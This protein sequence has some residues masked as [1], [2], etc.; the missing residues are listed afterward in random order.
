MVSRIREVAAT[1]DRYQNRE[2]YDRGSVGATPQLNAD[3]VRPTGLG[4]LITGLDKFLDG[5]KE[6]VSKDTL[7][8]AQK[9]GATAGLEPDFKEREDNTLAA[10]AYNRAGV[11]IFLNKTSTDIS[12][13]VNKI[14]MDPKYRNDP[15]GL[16]QALEEVNGAMSQHIPASMYPQFQVAFGARAQHAITQAQSRAYE[17]QLSSNLATFMENE[18]VLV[19]EATQA[20]RSGDPIVMAQAQ[21]E[22]LASV[23]RQIG[24]GLTPAEAM[25]RTL[26]FEKTLRG[27][28][29]IGEFLRQKPEDRL[30]YAKAFIENNPMADL[31]TPQEADDIKQKMW[32]AWDVDETLKEKSEVE[33]SKAQK[34]INDNALGELYLNPTPETYKNFVTMPGVTADQKRAAK[35]YMTENRNA[36][37]PVAVSY[38]ED[39]IYSGNHEEAR[40]ALLD[41]DQSRSIS[42]REI[43]RLMGMI[44]TEESGAGFEQ[45]EPYKEVL[46]RIK[47]DYTQATAFGTGLSPEGMSLR[48]QVYDKLRTDYPKYLRGE[49]SYEEVDPLRIYQLKRTNVKKATS[50]VGTGRE[51]TTQNGVVVVPQKYIDAPET[52]QQD[53]RGTGIPPH[54]RSVEVQK[55]MAD[56]MI[57]KLKQTKATTDGQ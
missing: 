7:R 19:A 2:N 37:D 14:A 5:A 54:L 12:T 56:T 23:Q 41:E 20:A 17:Q 22:Y 55:F 18:A 53:L 24:L 34:R 46:R 30:A 3:V 42:Q 45:T 4:E 8:A 11:E 13:R 57:D 35:S 29:A 40:Q 1:A 51:I 49:V 16:Q 28:A 25:K 43:R 21:Q 48:Q 32:Q 36:S 27:E 31:M 38:V 39:L 26:T 33:N 15:V 10:D 44:A 50:N 9:A 6:Q 47:T 52:Y